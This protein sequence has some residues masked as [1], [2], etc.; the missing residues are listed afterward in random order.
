M[1]LFFK[2]IF[3]TIIFSNL[4][5]GGD[6][7][8]SLIYFKFNPE[9]IKIKIFID[10]R[11]NI[12]EANKAD[13][14][15]SQIDNKN[16]SAKVFLVNSSVL[17]RINKSIDYQYKIVFYKE[18]QKNEIPIYSINF[19]V[20]SNK[21][22]VQYENKKE[23]EFLKDVVSD[24]YTLKDENGNDFDL[25][26]KIRQVKIISKLKEVANGKVQYLD[27][28]DNLKLYL[29]RKKDDNNF[30]KEEIIT[31]NTMED[32][33]IGHY[34]YE[35]FADK[36][37]KYKV[38]GL[39][40]KSNEESK[41]LIIHFGEVWDNP[42][43]YNVIIERNENII[44]I[45]YDERFYETFVKNRNKKFKKQ[46]VLRFL[47]TDYTNESI[48]IKFNARP[49]TIKLLKNPV[50]NFKLNLS[51]DK[52]IKDICNEIV[53]SNSNNFRKVDDFTI[54]F[55]P[56]F[57]NVP[58]AIFTYP[59]NAKIEIE[60]IESYFDEVEKLSFSSSPVFL[61]SFPYGK[62][63]IK[64]EWE[65]GI[66]YK[67]VTIDDELTRNKEIKF[68]SNRTT[69]IPYIILEKDRRENYFKYVDL[70]EKI[71]ISV[72]NNYSKDELYIQLAAFDLTKEKDVENFVKNYTIKYK[73]NY[74]EKPILYTTYK[75][76]NEKNY[77]DICSNLSYISDVF[78]FFIRFSF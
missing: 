21:L 75:T 26:E 62:Y 18:W 68:L 42:Y 6:K 53:L 38:S 69:K 19:L 70:P 57:K 32:F 73:D 50:Y 10:N 9:N 34:P 67:I 8:Y 56:E 14:Y 74:N 1:K 4:Y 2:F 5:A 39:L 28:N 30:G 33:F 48:Y 3:F 78:K 46:N 59:D 24:S 55:I 61:S 51:Y 66:D 36:N 25:T 76:V 58:F 29:K 52:N 15:I 47:N 41:N 71:D 12:T 35:I 65:E 31:V 77:K 49:E 45:K 20:E 23:K 16:G 27:F 60:K 11:F 22:L 72:D 43:E 64:A 44:E 37:E 63:R 13:Y 54:S 7:K 17:D 40:L